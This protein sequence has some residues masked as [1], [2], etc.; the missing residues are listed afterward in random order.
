MVK[1]NVT[2]DNPAMRYVFYIMKVQTVA[3]GYDTVLFD[4]VFPEC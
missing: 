2:R 4:R 3:L 1:A